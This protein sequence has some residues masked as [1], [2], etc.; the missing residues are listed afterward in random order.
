MAT[1]EWDRRQLCTDGSCIG[2]IGVDGLCKVCGSAAP[3][4]ISE[5]GNQTISVEYRD[6]EVDREDDEDDS[7]PESIDPSAP[8]VPAA[9]LAEWSERQLCPEG[10]CIGLLGEDGRCKVCGTVGSA[11]KPGS[12]RED[13]S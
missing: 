1:G 11:A 2:V 8:S 9:A 10:N 4:W 5:H 7:D 6:S 3:D 13:A 12:I